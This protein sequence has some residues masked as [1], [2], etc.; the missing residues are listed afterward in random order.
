VK[1]FVFKYFLPLV[2]LVGWPGLW[3]N[4]NCHAVGLAKITIKV[5][6]EVDQPVEGA[7]VLVCFFGG[8]LTKEA[9]TGITDG[10]GIFSMSANS[11]DGQVGGGV[12]KEGY[13]RT[14]FH[15]DFIRR[16]LGFWQPWNKEI[17]VVLRPIVNP[18]PMY[19]RNKYFAM[20]H[21]YG[22]E[23]GFDL[24]AGDWVA[25]Y[26][27]GSVADFIF[28]VDG[29]YNNTD[30]YKSNVTFTF[31]NPNDGIQLIKESTGGDFGVGSWYRLPRIAPDSGYHS[32]LVKWVGPTMRNNFDDEANYIFRV[33]SQT[34]QDGSL[35]S[36]LY[37]KIKG[38][39]TVSSFEDRISLKLHYYLNPDGTRNLEFDPKQNLFR[40]LPR[41]EGTAEP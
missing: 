22:K 30:D 12:G 9:K 24:M 34:D 7:E 2:I 32:K 6:D 4:P 21:E 26:G 18:V 17:R 13:Y 5:V 15:K 11:P 19:V 37:G 35:T 31:S 29:Y 10:N 20:P 27:E 41:G 38:E 1:S 8:C 23:F 25:P 14:S 40:N 36:A 3:Q 16:K 39:I 33:R 28:K